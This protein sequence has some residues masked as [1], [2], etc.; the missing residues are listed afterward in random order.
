MINPNDSFPEEKIHPITLLKTMGFWVPVLVGIYLTSL[1]DYLLFHSI[2][3]FFSILVG[4]TLFVI[5]W[6]SKHF[7]KNP[8]LLF[9]GIAYLFISSIDLL[10]TLSYKGMSIFKDYDY[11][12]N[13]LWIAAR[14]L[15]AVSLFIGF[16]F[17]STRRKIAPKLVFGG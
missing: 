15:E 13:Q 11:Y 10:H 9:I 4:C 6:N 7:I 12:A 17:L 3:E 1:Y 14:Y 2:A 8:Y 16:A 5:A